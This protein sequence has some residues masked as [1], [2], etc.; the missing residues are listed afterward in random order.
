MKGHAW[1][2][3]HARSRA[4]APSNVARSCSQGGEAAEVRRAAGWVQHREKIRKRMKRQRI[5][6]F[7]LVLILK[8][9]VWR[10][11]SPA[12]AAAAHRPLALLLDFL[13]VLQLAVRVV[14]RAVVVGACARAGAEASRLAGPSWMTHRQLTV[15]PCPG[16]IS[17]HSSAAGL[18][19]RVQR[20]AQRAPPAARTVATQALV[21]G[22]VLGGHGGAVVVVPLAVRRRGGEAS[23]WGRYGVGGTPRHYGWPFHVCCSWRA[24]CGAAAASQ[25]P[26]LTSPASM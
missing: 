12:L 23:E 20:T 26:S 11:R 17:A 18:V 2:A 25:R 10:R 24:G 14:Q 19:R 1:A 15:R 21:E 7:T 13:Q 16:R 6:L 5:K 3:Y 22:E 8:P 9:A 4:A